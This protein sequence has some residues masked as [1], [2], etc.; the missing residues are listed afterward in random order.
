MTNKELEFKLKLFKDIITISIIYL[1]NFKENLISN[2]I[3]NPHKVLEGICKYEKYFINLYNM[4]FKAKKEVEEIL[5]IIKKKSKPSIHIN[6]L[7]IEEEAKLNGDESTYSNE[8]E[9]TINDFLDKK[10]NYEDILN[11]FMEH[12]R[13][14]LNLI[15]DL[16]LNFIK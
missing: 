7:E 11:N 16:K 10:K 4:V 3:F 12:F 13:V 15:K 9:K 2:M 14:F 5:Y 8:L 6:I 1:R